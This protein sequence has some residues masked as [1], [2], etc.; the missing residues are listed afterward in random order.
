MRTNNLPLAEE[1]FNKAK[2]ICP[3]D[4][5]I[6]NELGTLAHARKNYAHAARCFKKALALLPHALNVTWEATVSNLAHALRKSGKYREALGMYEK[7]LALA[8]KRAGTYAAMGYTLH[9]LGRQ[10]E[11]IELCVMRS[12]QS[13]GIGSAIGSSPN[14]ALPS[15]I[16]DALHYFPL[17][18]GTTRR[19]A[20]TMMPSRQTCF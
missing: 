10:H 12:M 3:E 6:Y 8:P 7:A 16:T 19:S 2:A 4:P 5:L 18:A 9:L 1:F 20:S 11:A 13:D 17:F 15:W 14:P